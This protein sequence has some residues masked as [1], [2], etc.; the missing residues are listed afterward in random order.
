MKLERTLR[1]V[2]V[3]QWFL[4]ALSVYMPHETVADRAALIVEGNVA[5]VASGLDP[6]T[7]TI[8][9]YITL[10]ITTVHRGP[11]G[12]A[13]VILR[14]P[15]GSFAGLSNVLDAVPVYTVGEQV[16]VFLEPTP[17]GALRTA[18]MFFGKYTLSEDRDV[19]RRDLDGRL[20]VSEVTV[21]LREA[22][23][24]RAWANLMSETVGLRSHSR[25][26]SISLT[27]DGLRMRIG[28]CTPAHRSSI[29]S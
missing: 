2:L 19:A 14:E 15:G 26:S 23:K 7:G 16:V 20:A 5:E 11:N 10:S 9:T 3:C 25:I 17:D 4:A 13:Q 21:R 18:G 8:A 1:V 22:L 27:S 28:T 29:P 6:E 12:L 24:E